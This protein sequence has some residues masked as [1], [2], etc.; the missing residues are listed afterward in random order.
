MVLLETS[1]KETIKLKSW[2]AEGENTRT[3]VKTGCFGSKNLFIVF[4][5]TRGVVHI[6]YLDKGKIINHQT[7]IKDR[8][9]HLVSTLKEHHDNARQRTTTCSQKGKKVFRKPEPH[10]NE[11]PTLL[12]RPCSL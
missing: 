3:V 11:P 8:L 12:T 10:R 1:R 4:F 2:V 7:Y 5:S 6:S 9:K